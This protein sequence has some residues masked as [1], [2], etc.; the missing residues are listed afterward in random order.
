MG[1]RTTSS[2]GFPALGDFAVDKKGGGIYRTFESAGTV[3]GALRFVPFDPYDPNAF[4]ELGNTESEAPSEGQTEAGPEGGTLWTS[5]TGLFSLDLPEGFLDAVEVRT[6]EQWNGEFADLEYWTT[7]VLKD[8]GDW[9][10]VLGS[11]VLYPH[12]LE[13]Y[14]LTGRQEY[15]T[16]TFAEGRSFEYV[17]VLP[18]DPARLHPSYPLGIATHNLSQLRTAAASAMFPEGTRVTVS[19]GNAVDLLGTAL[20]KAYLNTYGHEPDLSIAED[21]SPCPDEEYLCYAI[22]RILTGTLGDKGSWEDENYYWYP[23]I[24]LFAVDKKTGAI[25]KVYNGLET[26]F[27]PFDPYDPNALG[28]AG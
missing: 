3:S 27:Y 16:L 2:T 10:E 1:G 4:G 24:F 25:Y 22:N 7:F 13:R 8:P 19:P 6:G 12:M 26:V 18:Q 17:L 20:I 5:P 15:S 9:D 28:F 11:L 14:Y 21:P 23:V